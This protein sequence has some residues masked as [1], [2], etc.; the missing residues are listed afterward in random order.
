MKRAERV[1]L[2]P[3]C[4][5]VC[6]RTLRERYSIAVWEADRLADKLESSIYLGAYV[7]IQGYCRMVFDGINNVSL[8][9]FAKFFL[10]G[11]FYCSRVVATTGSS[12]RCNES[13]YRSNTSECWNYTLLLPLLL[14]LVPF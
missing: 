11:A 1:S 10:W 4:S 7:P 3:V 12:R 6:R 8:S 5:I 13:I 14:V 2:S 9:H